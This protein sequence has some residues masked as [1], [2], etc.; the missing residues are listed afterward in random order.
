MSYLMSSI[1]E[2]KTEFIQ[3]YENVAIKRGLPAILGRIMAVF[4]MEG[5]E[6]SQKEVSDLTG[7]SVTS[8]SRTLE[9]MVRMGL[10]HKHKGSSHRGFVYH[11]NIDYHDL[12]IGGLSTWMNQAKA[13]I[14]EMRSLRLRI[15]NLE[16]QDRDSE[17]AER[18]GEMLKNIEEKTQSLLSIIGNAIE[19]LKRSKS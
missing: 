1:E 6:L 2:I 5:R 10:V 8:V 3:I 19:E 15:E 4:F 11:M 12:A 9:Q 16:P 18:I 17:E 7:Y 14:G 13:S